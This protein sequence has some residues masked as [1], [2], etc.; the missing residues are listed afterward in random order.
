MISLYFI[1]LAAAGWMS[2]KKD[3]LTL[4][5]AAGMTVIGITIILAFGL[6]GLAIIF[7]F[8]ISSSLIGSALKTSHKFEKP[9]RTIWQVAANGGIPFIAAVLFL[10]HPS[11]VWYGVFI[12]GIV[13]AASD[14]WASEIGKT[15][16]ER[17]FHF[18]LKRRVTGGLSGAVTIRGTTASVIGS[19]AIALISA[20]WLS[21]IGMNHF[22]FYIILFTAAGYLGNLLDTFLGAWLQAQY[23]CRKCSSYTDQPVHCNMKTEWQHGYYWMTNGFVNFLSSLFGGLLGALVM[24]L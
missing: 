22:L 18:R 9:K 12:G 3:L 20:V 21:S 11:Q 10:L 1:V 4:A 8:F 5:G 24:L 7:V 19:F 23:Y 2:Y 16:R 17:P 14:T 13:E 6:P 15:S